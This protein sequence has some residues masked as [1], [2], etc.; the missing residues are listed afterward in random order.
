MLSTTQPNSYQSFEPFCHCEPMTSTIEDEIIWTDEGSI[1]MDF[2]FDE[3]ILVGD[4]TLCSND[5]HPTSTSNKWKANASVGTNLLGFCGD[6]LW[7]A[8]SCNQPITLLDILESFPP[9][10]KNTNQ[11]QYDLS[12]PQDNADLVNTCAVTCDNNHDDESSHDSSIDSCETNVPFAVQM[13]IAQKKLEQSIRK[14][15]KSRAH[16]L[17]IIETMIT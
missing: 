3:N 7:N 16:Y 11:E 12:S 6:E 17:Q 2:D 4:G 13:E 5:I 1:C 8:P 14:S 9:L 15:Q 10:E